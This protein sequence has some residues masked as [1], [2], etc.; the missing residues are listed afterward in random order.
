MKLEDWERLMILTALEKTKGNQS[1]AARLLD[2]TPRQ[3]SFKVK[4]KFKL[5]EYTRKKGCQNDN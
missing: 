3:M 5:T 2:I 1:E 4:H